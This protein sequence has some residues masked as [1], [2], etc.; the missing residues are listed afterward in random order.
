MYYAIILALILILLAVWLVS[1]KRRLS[2]MKENVGNAM[3]Q[4]GV[5]L[6]S[7]FDALCALCALARLYAPREAQALTEAIRTHRNAITACSTPK[8]VLQQHSVIS[9]ACMYMRALAEQYP[10]ITADADYQ[11]RVDAIICYARMIRTSAL[12]YNDSAAK[13]NRELHTFPTLLIGGLLGYH[14]HEYLHLP[15]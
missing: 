4:F 8:D 14:P 1:T 13:L 12:I 7:Y 2:S 5:Q 15:N 10:D 11:K 6:S 9:D 3:N